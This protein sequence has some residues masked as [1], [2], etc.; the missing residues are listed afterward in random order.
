MMSRESRNYHEDIDLFRAAL[1]Y[2]QSET[3][4]SA[5]LV[6]KDY[7]SSL[8]LEDLVAITSPQWAFKG[9]TC[10]S[11]VHSDFYRMSE[12]LDFALFGPGGRTPLPAQQDDSVD[13]GPFREDR[14]AARLLQA[15]RATS[16]IQQLDAVHRDLEL[17]VRGDR[18]G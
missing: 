15:R 14:K 16:G 12:D 1:S 8:V 11:K 5:R 17:Q 9:G 18:P 6:E 7:Y 3:G 2:T 13:E 10:L 4:F